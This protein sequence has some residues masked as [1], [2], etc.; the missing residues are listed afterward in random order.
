MKMRNLLTLLFV[1]TATLPLI[2]AGLVAIPAYYDSQVKMVTSSLQESVNIK[3]NQLQLY[4]NEN[5]LYLQTLS[6]LPFV[7]NF[8]E[9]AQTSSS[10]PEA[11]EKL[12]LE[13]DDINQMLINFVGSKSYVDSVRVLNANGIV[14]A[15]N[16][17][18]AIGTPALVTSDI[19]NRAREKRYAYTNIFKSDRFKDRD[20]I[21]I[22]VA[23]IYRG[24]N[25]L[26]F[27][28]VVNS[29]KFFKSLVEDGV[30]SDKSVTV[31]FDEAS[32][33]IASN[34]PYAGP[35]IDKI[36]Q[37]NT[38]TDQWKRLNFRK[39]PSGFLEYTIRDRHRMSC[40]GTLRNLDWN[41]L[42]IL[43]YR[44]FLMP[45]WWSLVSAISFLFFII[46]FSVVVAMR[47][48]SLMVK[49]LKTSLNS[50]DLIKEGRHDIRLNTDTFI[51]EI[52]SINQ[53]FNYLMEH[54][55][56]ANC[57]LENKAMIDPLTQLYNRRM[58]EEMA[59]EAMNQF[60]V[61]SQ[62]Q[63]PYLIFMFIDID[64]FK[65]FNDRFGHEFGDRVIRFIGHTIR[66]TVGN[67]GFAC[68]HGGDEFII[69]ISHEDTI[70]DINDFLKRLMDR[71]AAGMNVR[72]NETIEVHCSIGVVSF[73]QHGSTLDEL[74]SHADDE[75]YNVKESGKGAVRFYQSE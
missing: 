5:L 39:Y 47:L 12:E 23:S 9:D 74:I 75:M 43:D 13:R 73:P 51:E 40:Y 37:P 21:H 41:V 34:S 36:A 14:M 18:D 65:N 2:L 6:Q 38:L 72:K 4:F 54:L 27:I 25:F 42:Q 28:C 1:M 52:N 44:D 19:L 46:L 15:S 68:R 26:G 56:R 22:C 67:L 11:I 31:V 70:R 48:S 35:D 33:I 57:E 10:E 61:H 58:F 62:A 17:I 8:L 66:N 20:S 53:S 64:D 49:T 63:Y 55:Q 32:Q 60:P 50:I 3:I 7:M 69:C 71:L 59:N 29:T 30:F 45:V 16:D 24:E